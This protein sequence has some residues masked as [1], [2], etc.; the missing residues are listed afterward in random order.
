[1]PYHEW[2][3][4]KRHQDDDAFLCYLVIRSSL[5]IHHRAS[6]RLALRFN[7][8]LPYSLLM[9]RFSRLLS[10]SFRPIPFT[11][12]NS[13]TDLKGPCSSRKLTIASAFFSPTPTILAASVDASA[14]L[15]FTTS[16]RAKW[17]VKRR[18]SARNSC[19]SFF[20]LCSS[21]NH[22]AAFVCHV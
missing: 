9:V 2:E 20:S 21:V 22:S 17:L 13:S 7:R 16:A 4:K 12:V 14:V 15:I 5:F 19:V 18:A 11:W 1:M 8:S 3:L 6:S 10:T